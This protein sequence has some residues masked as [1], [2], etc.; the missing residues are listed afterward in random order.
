MVV[1][2]EWCTRIRPLPTVRSM[3]GGGQRLVVVTAHS[4]AHPPAH[5]HSQS[6]A[7]IVARPTFFGGQANMRTGVE[8]FCRDR[9]GGSHGSPIYPVLRPCWPRGA[10]Q[11]TGARLGAIDSG[12]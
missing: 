6:A 11:E 10:S 8:C 1:Q 2:T 5:T 4:P 9:S 12:N 3:T 7:S